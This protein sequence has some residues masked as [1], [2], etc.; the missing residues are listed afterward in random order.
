MRTRKLTALLLAGA[1]MLSATACSSSENGTTGDAAGGTS[2]KLVVWTLAA[3]L[4]QF[5]ERYSEQTGVQVDVTVI[6]PADY[7]TKLTSALGAK[8]SE[9]DVIVGEPQMLPNFFEAGFFDDLSALD[10]DA[11]NQIA[12]YV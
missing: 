11:K 12:D 1:M 2:D 10:A 4:E 3:D 5:A 6:A 8:S 9:V 7:S